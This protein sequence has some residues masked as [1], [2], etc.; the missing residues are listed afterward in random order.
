MFNQCRP[1]DAIEKYNGD[2]YIQLIRPS[3][4]ARGKMV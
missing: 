3:L 4:T 1:A 2:V